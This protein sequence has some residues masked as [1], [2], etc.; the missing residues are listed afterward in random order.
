MG[1]IG[2]VIIKT[3]C[4]KKSGTALS[5]TDHALVS[6]IKTN[7]IAAFDLVYEKYWD[8]LQRYASTYIT[9]EDTCKEIV[10]DLF[11]NIYTK[12]SEL[13]INFSLSSYLRVA[14]HNR[15]RN[16]QRG[17]STYKRHVSFAA[18]KQNQ[19]DNNVDNFITQSDLERRISIYVNSLPVKYREVYMLYRQKEMR[20]KEMSVLL[21]RS[22]NTLDKQLRKV[23]SLLRSYLRDYK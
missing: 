15:I 17:E 22:P 19:A 1:E 7:H 13:D 12:R 2:N 8:P 14:L 21:G 4:M 5:I 9:D 20:P 18:R 10:Q 11:I 3:S 16:Y 6:L 23:L